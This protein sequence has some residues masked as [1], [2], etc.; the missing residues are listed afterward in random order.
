[1]WVKFLYYYQY[2]IME[3]TIQEMP[4]IEWL[5]DDIK[6]SSNRLDS[7]ADRLDI[8]INWSH[9]IAESVQ[10]LV[11]WSQWIIS[12]LQEIKKSLM[13]TEKVLEE[14]INKI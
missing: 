5:L 11:W 6:F 2:I 9:P 12:R 7:L 4:I 3:T 13:N 10:W 1:M 8:K 14:Q